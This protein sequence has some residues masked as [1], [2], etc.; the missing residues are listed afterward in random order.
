MK[1]PSKRHRWVEDA[2]PVDDFPHE[3]YKISQCSK[4]NFLRLHGKQGLTYSKKYLRDGKLLE[5]LPECK[6]TKENE[7]EKTN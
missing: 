2:M 7:H 3:V 4:C 1:K 6:P 5:T